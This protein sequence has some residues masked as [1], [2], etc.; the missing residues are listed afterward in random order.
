MEGALLLKPVTT[1]GEE[2]LAVRLAPLLLVEVAGGVG[3][4]EAT[5]LPSVFVRESSVVVNGRTH[6]RISYAWPLELGGVGSGGAVPWQGVRLTL[7]SAGE[8]VIWEVF[9]DRS[10]MSVVFVARSVEEAARREFGGPLP[11]RA[12]SVERALTETPEVVVARVIEDGPV[13]MGP[14]VHLGSDGGDVMALICRCMPPQA[15]ELVGQREYE[16]VLDETGAGGP[17]HMLAPARPDLG[18]R[19]PTVGGWP[20]GG[21]TAGRETER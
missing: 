11:G 1:L 15:R 14:I 16:L 13:P 3:P 19:L 10:E 7:N 2:T 4:G 6:V 18:L 9:R 12:F 8:P 20:G 17:T 21:A 5:G